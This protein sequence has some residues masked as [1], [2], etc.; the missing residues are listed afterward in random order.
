M[1]RPEDSE[2]MQHADG[3]L[4]ERSAREVED[5]IVRES[6]ARAKVV[7]IGQ[8]GELVRGHL[9]LSA[10]AVPEPR[11]A[12]IWREIDKRVEL[13]AETDAARADEPEPARGASVWRRM[14]SWLDRHRGHILT[15]VVS[16][17]AVAALALVL[18]P[19][20][21]S[22]PISGGGGALDVQPVAF[23]PAEIESL[24]TPG[25]TPT[26]F[27]LQDENGGATVIW[28]TPADTVEG[29]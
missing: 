25:G 4:D 24:D 3:E 27:Q 26:V 22:S 10:D 11:F 17:G 29:I 16:A 13:D 28:V 7:A 21:P 12:A 19:P 5:V 18:R 23:R 15:G 6:E 1:A 2:L 9:E 20:I 8:L 14:S